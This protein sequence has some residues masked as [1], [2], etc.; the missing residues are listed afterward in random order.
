MLLSVPTPK[1]AT[2]VSPMLTANGLGGT[3]G[4]ANSQRN[5]SS[6]TMP[7]IRNAKNV[8]TTKMNVSICQHTNAVLCISVQ[9]FVP[10]AAL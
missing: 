7:I 2:P 6:G 4:N 9:E 8:E 5:D 10:P 3:P 1:N